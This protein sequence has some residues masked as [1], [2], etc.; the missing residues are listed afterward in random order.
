M[1]VFRSLLIIAFL[2]AGGLFAGWWLHDYFEV[3]SPSNSLTQKPS[4]P[5]QSD[6]IDKPALTEKKTFA[7]DTQMF[8]H[9]LDEEQFDD[10]LTLYQEY[11]NANSE[12]LLQLRSVLM[13]TLTRWQNNGNFDLCIR[14]LERF[15]QYYYQDTEL[16]KIQIA[17]LESN[18]NIIQAIEFCLSAS[19]LATRESDLEYFNQNSRRL[20]KLL[21]DQQQYGAIENNLLLFQKL[22]STEPDYAFYHYALA[23][24][25]LAI[26]DKES[27]A[28]ELAILKLDR[29]FGHKASKTLTELFPTPPEPPKRKNPKAIPLT[30]YGQHFI[31]TVKI[32]DKNGATAALL[33]DTGA[34]LTTLPSQLLRELTEKKQASLSGYL[35]LKTANGIRFSQLYTLKL[36][37]IGGQ[38]LKNIEVAELDVEPGGHSNGLLGMNVLSKFMFHIDQNSQTLILIPR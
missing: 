11:E 26:G 18:Q 13:D 38:L 7:A 32:G 14:V 16:L 8:Q 10:A 23:E 33:I 30:A 6:N 24:I 15:T 19:L 36:F 9:Y 37:Q 28:G 2:F 1:T 25:Y 21:F 34:S 12:L 17:V 22:T 4:A 31:V 3:Q 35:E 29:E 20:A 5:S 27:A